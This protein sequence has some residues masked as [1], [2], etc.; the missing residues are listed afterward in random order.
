MGNRLL[1][2]PICCWLIAVQTCFYSWGSNMSV[3]CVEHI[4]RRPSTWL[5]PHLLLSAGACS[6]APA[7]DQYISCTQDAQQQTH[8]P[9]LLLSIDGTDRWT[10]G[11]PTVTCQVDSTPHPPHTRPML[12]AA[13]VQ[14]INRIGSLNQHENTRRLYVS[15]YQRTVSAG[16]I[17]LQ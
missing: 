13:I 11:C 14:W 3:Y 4:L 2:C 6:T 5:Y 7:I 9:P 15:R 17:L 8:R 16:F 1:R 12:A 10:E